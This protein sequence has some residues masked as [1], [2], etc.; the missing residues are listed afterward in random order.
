MRVMLFLFVL[1]AWD[2]RGSWRIFIILLSAPIIIFVMLA[3]FHVERAIFIFPVIFVLYWIFFLC[4]DIFHTD[5]PGHILNWRTFVSYLFA[6]LVVALFAAW[7]WWLIFDIE[8]R[9][10]RWRVGNYFDG[11]TSTYNGHMGLNSTYISCWITGWIGVTVLYKIGIIHRG[12]WEFR[13]IFIFSIS[14]FFLMNNRDTLAVI[15][16]VMTIIIFCVNLRHFT[17]HTGPEVYISY[18]GEY[19]V[20]DVSRRPVASRGVFC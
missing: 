8:E 5:V 12:A 18:N 13:G 11:L 7:Y 10:N 2:E 15:G 4:S 1:V 17:C 6:A 9:H 20:Y 19:W 3:Y 14:F 16:L